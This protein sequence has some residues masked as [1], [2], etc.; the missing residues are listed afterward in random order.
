MKLEPISKDENTYEYNQSRL[1]STGNGQLSPSISPELAVTY[2]ECRIPS[3]YLELAP[4][5]T[6]S[7]SSSPVKKSTKHFQP[8][9]SNKMNNSLNCVDMTSPTRNNVLPPVCQTPIRFPPVFGKHSDIQQRCVDVINAFGK[10]FGSN[11]TIDRKVISLINDFKKQYG[12]IMAFAE[13]TLTFTDEER[14][15]KEPPADPLPTESIYEEIQSARTPVSS[16]SDLSS[17][18]YCSHETDYVLDP[19]YHENWCSYK[20]AD[21]LLADIDED[22]S[23]E[24]NVTNESE[25]PVEQELQEIPE[26]P[27][28]NEE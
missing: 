14:I 22:V 28:A 6:R 25:L 3:A 5:F 2:T 23:E 19:D 10:C 9:K 24:E 15:V 7:P 21:N 27:I 18:S 20:P 16:R 12:S 4:L 13:R 1:N 26:I 11:M 17:L 8:V